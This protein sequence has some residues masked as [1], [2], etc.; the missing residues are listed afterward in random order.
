MAH[1]ASAPSPVALAAR[2]G[3]RPTAP[4]RSGARAS[5]APHDGPPLETAVASA[6]ASRRALLSMAAAGL[7]GAA[8]PAQARV[9]DRVIQPFLQR[10]GIG[11]PLAEE[12]A[13]L[14]E[15]RLA[16]ER[17]AEEELE[18]VRAE[19]E[20]EA[21]ERG[22]KGNVL[23]ST[24]FGVD[25]V[26]ITEFIALLGAI[27]GGITSRQRKGEV[28]RL[29]NQLRAIN[30]QL[31]QQARAGTAYAPGLTY[32]PASV[33]LGA[34]PMAPPPPAARDPEAR[35]QKEI[36]TGISSV[37]DTEQPVSKE[38]EMVSRTLREG[39]RLLKEKSGAAAMVR[40]E[41]ALMLSKAN[42]DKL[43]QRRAYRGLAA[44]E[45]LQGQSK[46]AIKHL[47]VVLKLSN[48]IDN[49]V[50]DADAYGSIADLHT[51][52]GD[53]DEAAKYYDLYISEMRKSV[54][55]APARSK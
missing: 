18:R 2:F 47:L 9:G 35:L 32:A 11:G 1:L 37:P 49:H 54:T 5:A 12:E 15:L 36:A 14:L 6:A 10:S 48:E 30:N 27:T 41:K 45:R 23:C 43:A 24:P 8:R 19:L 52:L 21:R 31:R 7:V 39:K 4:H 20:M 26:G 40:F 16:K 53:Y 33:S 38:A 46:A 25:V 55:A 28:E 13:E 42:G 51:D 3:G 44:A 17:L 50:G 22:G 34:P 29:N